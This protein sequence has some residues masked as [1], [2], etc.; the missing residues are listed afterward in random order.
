MNEHAESVVSRVLE[1]GEELIWAGRPELEQPVPRG[2]RYRKVIAVVSIAA[3]PM[4]AFWLLPESFGLRELLQEVDAGTTAMVIGGFA[5]FA[6]LL[7][8]L[9]SPAARRAPDRKPQD[10]PEAGRARNMVGKGARQKEAGRVLRH[11]PGQL[12]AA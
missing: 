6:L 9:P 3:V 10:R 8:F 4:F 12:A 2:S 11:R 7:I 5:L 1:P